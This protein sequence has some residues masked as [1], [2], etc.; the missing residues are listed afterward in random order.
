MLASKHKLETF[1]SK[2][3]V[4]IAIIRVDN[5]VYASAWYMWTLILN[6]NS[7]PAAPMGGY[8]QNG[9]AEQPIGFITRIAAC[10][11]V[12]ARKSY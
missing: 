12:L 6:S 4:S 5:G 1:A 11:G 8:W 3:G 9:S 2:F 7:S 10:N